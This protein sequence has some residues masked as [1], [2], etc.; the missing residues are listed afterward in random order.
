MS[1]DAPRDSVPSTDA[2]EPE[3]TRASLDGRFT[4]PRQPPPTSPRQAILIA[5]SV[6][7]VT[8]L[9]V[10]WAFSPSRAGVTDLLSALAAVYIPGVA[11]TALWLRRRGELRFALVPRGG[12]L[13]LG[14][15]IAAV[16]YGTAMGASLLIT[17]HG[18]PQEA[19]ILRLYLHL[20]GPDV[21]DRMI[22]GGVV[23]AIAALEEIVWRGLAMRALSGAFGAVPAL[24]VSTAL[25]G[26]AH[27]PTLFLLADPQAGPNPLL[28]A[29]ALG[30]GLVWGRLV[31]LKHERLAPA[32]FAH[33]FFSWAVA[34]FPLWRP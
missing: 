11:L 26:A 24:L 3:E 12:D 6:T 30:C 2:A 16:L 31:L 33:A 17:P 25:Y 5:A 21:S 4:D 9:G 28:V 34:S 27:L 18:S 19:W 32:V 8:A 10:A 15:L 23:F 22:L 7:L 20:G 1:A 14:A 13:A 29:A